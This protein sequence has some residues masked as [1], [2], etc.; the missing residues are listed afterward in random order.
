MDTGKYY[1][2]LF[3]KK[4]KKILSTSVNAELMDK[5]ITHILANFR[6]ITNDSL[7]MNAGWILIERNCTMY[8]CSCGR[9]S[10]S[11]TYL[12]QIA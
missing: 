12:T 5:T 3:S 11:K 1:K 8:C 9:N 4:K 6:L 10:S 7:A 2:C